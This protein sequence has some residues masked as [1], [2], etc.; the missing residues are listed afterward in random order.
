M[1]GIGI[2]NRGRIWPP[3]AARG[4]EERSASEDR[5]FPL[6][7]RRRIPDFWLP[8]Q[9]EINAFGLSVNQSVVLCHSSPD[10]P[11]KHAGHSRRSLNQVVRN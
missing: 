9:E 8:Q 11:R 10:S 4:K 1:N 5:A 2:L 7:R 3:P 6:G